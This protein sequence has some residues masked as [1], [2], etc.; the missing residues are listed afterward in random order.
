MLLLDS[1]AAVVTVDHKVML[2]RLSRDVGEVQTALDRFKSY[3]SDSVQPVHM[4][5]VRHLLALLRVESLNVLYMIRS[6]SIVM[7][8]HY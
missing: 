4:N 6:C 7:Q 2:H 1:S 8:H 5:G 3:L